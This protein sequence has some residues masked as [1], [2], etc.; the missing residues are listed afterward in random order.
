M[1]VSFGSAH[2]YTIEGK[3]LTLDINTLAEITRETLEECRKEVNRL[4]PTGKYCTSYGIHDIIHEKFKEHFP[5][6]IISIEP[7][8]TLIAIPEAEG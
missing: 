6:G 3:G 7:T 1:Y 2:K 5:R 4:F 8:D